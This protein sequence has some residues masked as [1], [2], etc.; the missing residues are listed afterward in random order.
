M[1][2]LISVTVLTGSVGEATARVCDRVL[3]QA[4]ELRV[5]AILPRKSRKKGQSFNGVTVVPTTER[6][7][8]LGQGCSCCTVRSDL[9]TKVQKI[10]EEQTA[11]HIV[12]Q[13]SPQSDL[14]TLAKTFTVADH[15]GA[16]LSDV[17]RIEGFVSVIDMARFMAKLQTEAGRKHI[18]SIELANVIVVDG[19]SR[20]AV[21]EYAQV[22]SIIGAINPSARVER[23]DEAS[24]NLSSLHV[25][26][27][28]DLGVAENRSMDMSDGSDGAT[29]PTLI[30]RFVYQARRPFHP[31]RL[32][33][34]LDENW[35]GVIRAQGSFWVASR[36]EFARTLDVAGG[37]R[38]SSCSGMWWAT[39]PEAQRPD[40][41]DFKR[42]AE[43]IWHPEFG[44]RH[45]A[46]SFVCVG[47]DEADIRARLDRCLLTEDELRDSDAWASM[48][49]SFD[50]P[51]IPA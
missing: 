30:S 24:F 48:P 35:A 37:S 50:W 39:V 33:A 17:A 45:Q 2:D 42:Y 12:I 27:P 46:L 25:D 6:F 31:V 20:V 11:D 40:S 19:A 36:P 43:S 14:R 21:E 7:A 32:H 49:D 26:E 29:E 34:V 8:R 51:E 16:V 15:D 13:T 44:D 3:Q 1:S 5:S 38:E 10:A 9:M 41:P 28:F 18:E 47:V 4:N 23:A 22:L